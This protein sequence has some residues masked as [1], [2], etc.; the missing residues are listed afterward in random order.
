MLNTQC[1]ETFDQC[2]NKTQEK[3]ATGKGFVS[4]V[5]KQCCNKQ[6]TLCVDTHV[7]KN[8][9]LAASPRQCGVGNEKRSKTK[10][11]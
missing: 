9:T 8:D 3:V 2:D 10:H 4:W 11:H 7:N 6:A 1:G 5:G